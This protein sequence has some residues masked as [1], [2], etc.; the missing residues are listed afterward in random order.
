MLWIIQFF[1]SYVKP[2]SLGVIGFLSWLLFHQR[3]T[4]K[5]ENELINQ[6]LEN[7]IKVNEIQRKVLAASDKIEPVN[8]NELDS[9]NIKRMH[10]GKL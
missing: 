2:I 3:N 1:T 6:D 8:F 10:T 9:N 5:V 4:L 7:A